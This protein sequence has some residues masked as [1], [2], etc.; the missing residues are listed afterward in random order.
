MG[1]WSKLKPK[2]SWL[3]KIWTGTKIAAQVSEFI[4]IV[5]LPATAVKILKG[6][7]AVAEARGGKNKAT[8]AVVLALPLLRELGLDKIPTHKLHLGVELLL[9]P[10]I[11]HGEFDYSDFIKRVEAKRK[12]GFTKEEEEILKALADTL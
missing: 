2:K 9:D 10:D 11:T 12:E 4:P 5:G 7:I 1:F 3:G 6:T 8:S